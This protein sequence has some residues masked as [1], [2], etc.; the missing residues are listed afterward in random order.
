LVPVCPQA[1]D[2]ESTAT[3]ATMATAFML[4]SRMSHVVG[5]VSWHAARASDVDNL[6]RYNIRVFAVKQAGAA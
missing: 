5:R 6:K 2:T 3:A 4:T 1:D